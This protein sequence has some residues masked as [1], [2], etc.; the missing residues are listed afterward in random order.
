[1]IDDHQRWARLQGSSNMVDG[2]C[3]AEAD[4]KGEKQLVL[5][6][7]FGAMLLLGLQMTITV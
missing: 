4:G 3:V 7:V 2:W 5:L 6:I 1:M